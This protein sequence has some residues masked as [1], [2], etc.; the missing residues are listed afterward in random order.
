MWSAVQSGVNCGCGHKAHGVLTDLT[1]FPHNDQT[2][3]F[4]EDPMKFMTVILLAFSATAFA[5]HHEMSMDEMKKLPY[6]QHKKMMQENLEKKSAMIEE[7]KTC[8]NNSKDND[9]LM[10]CH[11]MMREEKHAMMKD[12]KKKK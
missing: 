1:L 2:N 12:M 8:V 9:G 10:D 7:S 11:K 5:G 4:K 6:D 3:N